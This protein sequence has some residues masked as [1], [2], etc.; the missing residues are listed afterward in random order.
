MKCLIF[1]LLFPVLAACGDRICEASEIGT[2]IDCAMINSN[3]VCDAYTN[4]LPEYDPDC[5]TSV[6]QTCYNSLYLYSSGRGGSCYPGNCTES[7]GCGSSC[8]TDEQCGSGFC[9]TGNCESVCDGCNSTSANYEVYPLSTNIYFGEPSF[10]SF[11]VN[12]LGGSDS[13]NLD[14]EGPCNLTHDATL[15]VSMGYNIAVVGVK[16]CE[17]SG[18]G[19]VKLIVNAGEA[20][21]VVHFLS[22]SALMR[23]IG[24][25]PSGVVGFAMMSSRMG[26]IPLEVKTWVG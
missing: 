13:V 25:M 7:S 6:G 18:L 19:S 4:D 8:S 24:D 2:C 16:N 14:V 12:K 5:N 17:F 20:E 26:G 23:S 11:R 10:V 9:V 3:Y 15:D 22:Y 1:F 21:G